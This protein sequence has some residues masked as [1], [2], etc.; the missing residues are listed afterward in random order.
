MCSLFRLHSEASFGL[1]RR[2]EAKL[3][4]RARERRAASFCSRKTQLMKL[5]GRQNDCP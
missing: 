3:F 4:R 1:T 2:S 5:R